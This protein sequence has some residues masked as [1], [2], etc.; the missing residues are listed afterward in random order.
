MQFASAVPHGVQRL[1]VQER[2]LADVDVRDFGFV[3]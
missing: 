2:I 1:Q 3:F